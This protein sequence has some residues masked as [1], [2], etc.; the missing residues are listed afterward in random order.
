[1]SKGRTFG[2]YELIEQIGRGGMGVVYKARQLALNRPVALKMILAGELA[3]AAS[4]E[5]FHI[6][7][8]AAAKLNHPNIVPIFDIGEQDGNHYFSMKLVEGESLA[9]MMAEFAL[10]KPNGSSLPKAVLRQAHSQIARLIATLARAVEY[11]H[12]HGILHRDLK[13]SNI[14]I[15]ADGTPYLTDFGLA[16]IATRSDSVTETGDIVGSINYMAPEQAKG[17]K[18]SGAAD[19][20]SL[21]AILYELLTS[22]PPFRAET[23]TETLRQLA[24]HEA[25]SPR[26]VN[27]LVDPDLATICLKCL[28]KN[29]LRR[30]G[31]AAELADDLDRW[32]RFEPIRA[33][34]ITPIKRLQ[35]WTRRN[36]VGAT[37]ILTLCVA[38]GTSAWLLH[39]VNK[40]RLKE[41]LA[42]NDVRDERD[43]NAR[44]AKETVGLLRGNLEGLWASTDKRYLKITSEQ[45]AAL[46]SRPIINVTNKA[47][48]MRMSVGLPANES[49]VD[50][51]RR[52]A[53][54]LAY[55]EDQMGRHMG[56]EIRM[57]LRLYKFEGDR[58]DA[59][60][61]GELDI[62]RSGAYPVL[63]L[64]KQNGPM[65]TLV[66][67][68]NPGKLGV[69]FTRTNSDIRQLTD[70]KGR[71]MAFGETNATISFM[72][73]TKLAAL[74]I[75][76]ND[77][78]D[79]AFLDSATEFQEDVIEKGYEPTLK[80]V[81]ELTSHSEVLERVIDG[82][83]DAGICNLRAFQR[84]RSRGLVMIPGTVFVN[85]RNIWIGRESL[86]PEIAQAFIVAMTNLSGPDESLTISKKEILSTTSYAR[87]EMPPIS[88]EE[89]LF[90]LPDNA[91]NGY[92]TFSAEMHAGEIELVRKMEA[93]FPWKPTQRAGKSSK[94]AH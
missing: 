66:E 9:K 10:P 70:I 62:L 8:E 22:K 88:K 4:V 68:V 5:R 15:D 11:A 94:S 46:I 24:E 86:P 19:I 33:R 23:P 85:L 73:Q 84:H 26:L 7:A 61:K 92:R 27:P 20:Y 64:L 49:P 82:T 36:R 47:R 16:K 28:E 59:L 78:S 12:A 69:F 50:E 44:L 67:Q 51:S 77:L 25:Q 83:F 29:P 72:A 30:Y 35:R 18:V 3:S 80:R 74:G 63:R 21:G 53:L 38:L 89:I 91:T 34:R 55:L 43:Q 58:Y 48:L 52:Y 45:L 71:S 56:R 81:G 40:E 42:L 65:R 60:G 54:L 75:T 2:D 90:T 6:E 87:G 14:L 39:L 93:L 57:D 41:E 76:T 17:L 1:M 79:Y 13:P 31:S 32:Q 37:L